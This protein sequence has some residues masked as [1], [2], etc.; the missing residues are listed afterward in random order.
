MTRS[1]LTQAGKFAAILALAAVLQVLVV[2]RISVLG[3]T[4]DLFLVLT[5]IVALSHGEMAGAIFGF[6]MGVVADTV[7][8]QPLG[9][10]AFIYLLAGYFV[11]RFVG[12]FGVVRAWG[13]VLLA[14]ATSF[15][16]QLVYGLFQYIVGPRAA[17]LT[18]VGTQMIPGAVLDALVCV[19]VY[20]AL[21][22]M[23]LLPAAAQTVAGGSQQ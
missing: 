1:R 16:A 20:L 15:G 21:V 7:F 17:F 14:G 5:V 8:F 6:F 13:L 11:G 3:V 18:V 22:R 19:P 23:R 4:A 9:V 12:R 2:S 10:R